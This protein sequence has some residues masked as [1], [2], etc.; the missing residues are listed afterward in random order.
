[1][2]AVNPLPPQLTVQLLPLFCRFCS[3][4][5]FCKRISIQIPTTCATTHMPMLNLQPSLQ[6]NHATLPYT[7]STTAS[8]CLTS[9][10]YFPFILFCWLVYK[11]KIPS[12]S[13]LS[14]HCIIKIN[15]LTGKGTAEPLIIFAED[16]QLFRI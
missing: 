12:T 15:T 10:L 13:S 16:N 14:H 1:M 9:W 6:V 4:C 7:P 8:G 11:V 5:C 2:A 3:F